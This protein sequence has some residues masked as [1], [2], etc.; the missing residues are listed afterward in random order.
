MKTLAYLLSSLF[1]FCV[2]SINSSCQI[3]KF[4]I[5]DLVQK[6]WGL[7]GLSNMTNDMV[8]DVKSVTI[9]FNG[10]DTTS[11]EYYL[12]DSIVKVF[13]SSK[14]GNIKEGK[15]IVRRPLP[16]SG[17]QKVSTRIFNFEILELNS[18][19]LVLKNEMQQKLE[20]LLK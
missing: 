9:I 13:N 2:I 11:F 8:F 1:F 16:F 14:V 10:K 19:K 18:R 17:Q 4:K 20:Y 3:S 12:S 7:Q 5:A 6:K 15:F